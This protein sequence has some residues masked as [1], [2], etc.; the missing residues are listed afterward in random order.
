MMEMA[1]LSQS[2]ILYLYSDRKHIKIDLSIKEWAISG[3]LKS[4]NC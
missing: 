2:T 3:Q 1:E 4:V